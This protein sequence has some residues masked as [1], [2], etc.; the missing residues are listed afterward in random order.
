VAGILNG[1]CNYILT[2]MEDRPLV[3]RRAARGPAPGLR[4]GRP[5][6]GRR[7]LRRRPQDHPSWRPWPSAARR[8]SRPPRSRASNG[9][10]LDIKLAKDLGYRI[11][12]VASA[13]R[14]ADGVLVRVHP[15]LAPLDHPLAQAGGA[16]NALFI[17]GRRIGRIFVQGPGAGA[18]PTAAAVAA[19]IADV[20]TGAVR[21]VF[22]APAGDL[23]PFIAVD[24]SRTVGKAYLRF[25]VRDEPGAIAAI[26]ET[27]AECG[28][29][30]DSFLQKPVEG[31]GGVPIVLVTHATAESV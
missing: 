12:L 22:Q 31:A 18:G 23:K 17:E 28:V 20:M 8:T 29:S 2:E 16:L 26:S 25:L 5:D 4:R 9:E 15:S 11:K 14:S 19:D 7:R 13:S 10:L 27:L 1:T 24:P 6:H 30:I 21:P 3:R